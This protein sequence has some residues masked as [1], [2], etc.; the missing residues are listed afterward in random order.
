MNIVCEN[1]RGEMK[2]SQ[3][4]QEK[5]GN[6][7]LAVAQNIPVG[8]S[9]WL[10]T[11]HGNTTHISHHHDW[12]WWGLATGVRQMWTEKYELC[13]P[14]AVEKDIVQPSSL[15][16][17][18]LEYWFSITVYCSSPSSGHWWQGWI[19]DNLSGLFPQLSATVTI[20]DSVG[21]VLFCT[22]AACNMGL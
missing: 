9:T 22:I 8:L 11:Q 5:S 6:H 16:N 20:H 17:P 15:L 4:M 19:S 2:W 18:F 13:I 3:A 10:D 21:W 12:E 1:H 7:I 14:V